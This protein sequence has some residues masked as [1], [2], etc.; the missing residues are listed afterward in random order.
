[1]KKMLIKTMLVALTVS[2]VLGFAQAKETYQDS[3]NKDIDSFQTFFK[4]KFSDIAFDEFANGVYA[5][6]LASREQWLE[7]EDFPPYEFAVDTGEELFDEA[8]ANGKSYAS[9]F[10]NEGLG[11]AQNFPYFDDKRNEIITLDVAINDCRVKN[12]EA[13]LPYGKGE[14]VNVAAYMVYSS[15]DNVL[16][17]KVESE[18]AYNAYMAGKKF[19]YSKRGQL[20]FSCADCHM[21]IV[22]QRLRADITS[23]ALGHTTGFPAYRFAWNEMGSL[24]R[25]Y[26]ECNRN[27]RALPFELQ[28]KEYR[29]L[30][31]FEAVMNRG[32]KINGPSSRK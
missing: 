11:I 10:E 29:Q 31:F 5:I 2:S 24:H 14:L 16:D 13:P 18:G 19:F 26:E 20:N 30:E 17:I 25:R 1:M 23:T 27:V 28:G 6:D 4:S 12:G 22:G 15:R 21:R 7:M 32:L 8:F 9:C 3:V